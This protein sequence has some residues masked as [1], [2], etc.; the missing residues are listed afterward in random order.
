MTIPCSGDEIVDADAAAPAEL[1]RT[2]VSS[3]EIM[4]ELTLKIVDPR[5]LADCP[6]Y[7]IGEV[8]IAGESI[9][10]GYWKQPDKTEKTFVT[11]GQQRFLRTGDLGFVSA[12][13][14]LYITGRLKDLIIIEGTNYAPEDIEETAQQAHIALYDSR[15]AA[16]AV[17]HQNALP[18]L[19]VVCEVNRPFS[20]EIDR[21]ANDIRA[22]VQRAV[23]GRY[24]L[25][26]RE[27]VLL[28]NNT[29]P[30]TTSGKIQRQRTK[31]LYLVEQLPVLSA[32]SQRGESQR[33]DSRCNSSDVSPAF[34]AA[35]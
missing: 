30:K 27:T 21:Y 11:R 10:S 14:S 22:A 31:L 8:W 20:L 13:Q 15:I 18:Q 19:V 29:I 33:T 12:Q 17:T 35:S 5:T 1:T 28:G 32:T 24:Q 4:P 6:A 34:T 16:F 2:V 9:S 23:Y 26:V 3:G 7:H 25:Q